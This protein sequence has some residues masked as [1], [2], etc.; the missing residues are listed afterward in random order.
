MNNVRGREEQ[1]LFW[2]MSDNPTH[3]L[4]LVLLTLVYGGRLALEVRTATYSTLD[5]ETA[6]DLGH[7]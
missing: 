6:E 5:L 4:K 1:I 2:G 7:I 3:P